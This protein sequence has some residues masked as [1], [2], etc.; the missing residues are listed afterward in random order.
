MFHSKLKESEKK[1]ALKQFSDRRTKKNVINSTKALS[2]G[3]NV[4]AINM[5]IVTAF[6]SKANT[7]IQR[8]TR[9]CRYIEGKRAI[10]FILVVPN[11]QEEEWLKKALKDVSNVR[12]FESFE[13]FKQ[14]L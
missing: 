2:E 12:Y 14:L 1:T 5:G 3:Y 13:T 7:I 8:I 4:P 6:T 9:A 11:T 10:L